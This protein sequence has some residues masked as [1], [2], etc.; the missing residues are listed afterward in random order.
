MPGE[1]VPLGEAFALWQGGR[2]IGWFTI[3]GAARVLM[4]VPVGAGT[5]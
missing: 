3:H 1:V 5:S 4:G 2:A